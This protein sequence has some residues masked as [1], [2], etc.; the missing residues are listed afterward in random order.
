MQD[1]YNRAYRICVAHIYH[2]TSDIDYHV[3]S[4][5]IGDEKIFEERRDDLHSARTYEVSDKIHFIH[6]LHFPHL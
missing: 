4:Y 2:R 6:D 1:A 3:I 5:Y